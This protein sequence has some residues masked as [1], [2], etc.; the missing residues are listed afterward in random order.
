[1][2]LAGHMS[3]Y[4]RTYSIYVLQG[5]DVRFQEGG[6]VGYKKYSRVEQSRVVQIVLCKITLKIP[7]KFHQKYYKFEPGVCIER[8]QFCMQFVM[9][10]PISDDEDSII[11]N[12][13]IKPI[14]KWKVLDIVKCPFNKY[15]KFYRKALLKNY[16][17]GNFKIYKTN[18]HIYC[19]C[20]FH[21]NCNTKI[22]TYYNCANMD[23]NELFLS[24]LNCAEEMKGCCFSKCM[25]APRCRPFKATSNPKP[26]RKLPF[27]EKQK[28][29]T[30]TDVSSCQ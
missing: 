12:K 1:M 13:T 20:C 2:F 27:E 21:H 5:C 23:C 8:M 4:I 28:L 15:T 22:D 3:V 7:Y 11:I 25:D 18:Q 6:V 26:F 14:I 19:R 16:F 30:P 10:I 17:H 9:E 24:C 29:S